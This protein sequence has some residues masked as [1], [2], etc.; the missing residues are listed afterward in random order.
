VEVIKTAISDVLLLKPRVFEDSRGFF[1]ESFNHAKW[2]QETGLDTSFVQDNHSSSAQGVVRG[3]HCQMKNVQSKLVR[4][5]SG[6]I[7]DVALDL[8][9]SSPTFGKY[10]STILSA[11]NKHQLWVPEGFSHA[12][13][14]LED[15]SEVLYKTTDY[16]DPESEQCIKWNDPQLS[17][18]WP[19]PGVAVLSEKDSSAVL[20]A[21]AK[22]FK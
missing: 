22:Y 5:V 11:E 6:S 4:V 21:D 18:N 16:Y 17:V 13:M 15:N 7:F 10:V 20:F 12:F 9:E 14:A 1:M 3:F 19:D 8:R 2:Q